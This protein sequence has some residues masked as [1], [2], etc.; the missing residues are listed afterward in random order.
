[1]H[2]VDW[3]GTQGDAIS[4]V[5]IIVIFIAVVCSVWSCSSE[6]STIRR[7]RRK[8]AQTYDVVP[9]E[10]PFDPN[11]EVRYFPQGVRI[12][13][14]TVNADEESDARQIAI[15]TLGTYFAGSGI[16]IPE[17]LLSVVTSGRQSTFTAH[18]FIPKYARAF[19]TEYIKVQWMSGSYA[20]VVPFNAHMS[21]QQQV[22]NLRSSIAKGISRSFTPTNDVLI[23]D[24]SDRRSEIWCILEPGGV[25]GSV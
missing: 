4:A 8:T 12:A 6:S 23:A 11:L 20:A 19:D 3:N 1:M 10:S 25:W 9:I 22:Q 15:N 18:V 2:H 7:I 14:I 5:L 13:S 17:P 24:Y 16:A 21:V